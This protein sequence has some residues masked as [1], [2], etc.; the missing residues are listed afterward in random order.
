MGRCAPDKVYVLSAVGFFNRPNK[1]NSL[2]CNFFLN[3]T[4]SAVQ[5]IQQYCTDYMP[6]RTLQELRTDIVLVINETLLV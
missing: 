5:C 2:T 1:S 6:H 4:S 3:T